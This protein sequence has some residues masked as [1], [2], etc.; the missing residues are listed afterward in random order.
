MKERLARL[1]AYALARGREASTWQGLITLLSA[2]GVMLRPEQQQAILLAGVG[3]VG[4]LGAL[5]PNELNKGG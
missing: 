5:F 2:C 1:Y 3:L 4:L